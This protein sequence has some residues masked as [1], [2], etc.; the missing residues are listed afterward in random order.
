[1]RTHPLAD[2]SALMIAQ[3]SASAIK[4][5]PRKKRGNFRL[6]RHS[7]KSYEVS[8]TLPGGVIFYPISRAPLRCD[9]LSVPCG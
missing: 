8:T 2:M 6:G 4:R 9:K 5:Q 7:G 1:V 3:M